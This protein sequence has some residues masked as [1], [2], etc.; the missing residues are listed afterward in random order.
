MT[1]PIYL[2]RLPEVRRQRDQIIDFVKNLDDSTL[3]EL[4]RR[5]QYPATD[6]YGGGSNGASGNDISRPTEAAVVQRA[7]GR[8]ITDE[9]GQQR[10]TPDDWTDTRDDVRQAISELFA[11]LAEALGHIRSVDRKRQYVMAIADTASG[12]VSSL[13]G[14]CE[15]CEADVI[16]VGDDRLRAGFCPACHKAWVRT[17]QGK[18]R[19]DR[20]QFRTLRLQRTAS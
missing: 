7:G 11:T 5:G 16:G 4:L 9:H 8:T 17:D 1:A 20:M 3:A 2:P 18:G 13:Q 10:E 14:Q 15:A 12:R 6:G 19:M